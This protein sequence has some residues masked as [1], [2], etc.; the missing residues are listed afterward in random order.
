[1][2]LAILFLTLVFLINIAFMISDIDYIFRSFNVDPILH[3]SGGLFVAMFFADYL[4]HLKIGNPGSPRLK[5]ILI[6]ISVT[7]FVGVIWEFSEYLTTGFFGNYLY[8]KYKII[9]CMGNLDDTMSDLLMDILGAITFVLAFQ[10]P[11]NSKTLRE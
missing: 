7:L 1:M 10:G 6:L 8:G 9:C 4:R 11:L 2:R 3:F 5:K